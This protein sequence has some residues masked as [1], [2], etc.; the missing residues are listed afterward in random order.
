M[1]PALLYMIFCKTAPKI[2]DVNTTWKVIEENRWIVEDKGVKKKKRN[3][4]MLPIICVPEIMGP[5]DGVF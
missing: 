1:E 4:A 5:G 2:K 3:R